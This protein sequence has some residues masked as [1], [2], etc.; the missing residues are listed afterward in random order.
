ME[1]PCERSIALRCWDSFSHLHHP[2]HVHGKS[3]QEEFEEIVRD[4]PTYV[5]DLARR[6]LK[7]KRDSK[8]LQRA[9]L[10][11]GQRNIYALQ[12]AEVLKEACLP[13]TFQLELLQ[14]PNRAWVRI[15]VSRR[16][17]T[18][19][20]RL[21]AWQKFRSWF[22]AFSGEVWL[23][24]IAPLVA[25]V[26][27]RIDEGCSFSRPSELH[28]ALTILEQIGRVAEDKRCS[29][30]ATWLAH[31]SSWKLELEASARAPRPA[32]PYTVAVLVSLEVFVMD[33]EQDLY[34]RFV[35]WTMLVAC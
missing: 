5:L 8:G 23:K 18:V 27:E 35:A 26:E 17:K 31:M 32:K 13:V 25:Y 19:R 30:D 28:A 10:E 7:R 33:V 12:L 4:S 34:V 6:R 3:I 16:S 29:N 14:D 15:F 21:R 9:E 24:T 22:I 20:N 1:R 2:G 11:N